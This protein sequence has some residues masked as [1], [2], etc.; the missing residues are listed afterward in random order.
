[1]DEPYQINESDWQKFKDFRIRAVTES[2]QAFGDTLEKVLSYPDFYWIDG[3]KNKKVFVI[4]DRDTYVSGLVF[5]QDDDGI[6]SVKSLWTDPA[7]RG[8]GLAKKIL[9]YVIGVAKAIG[10]KIIELGINVKQ[11]TA[12]KLYESLGFIQVK[13]LP[14]L[15]MGDGSKNDLLVMRLELE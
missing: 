9:R 8:K 7:Y 2:P 13:R 14:D 15:E 6:W 10:V 4:S 1:M 5:G 11:G 12:I 3:I